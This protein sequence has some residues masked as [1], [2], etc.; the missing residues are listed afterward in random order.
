MQARMDRLP[1]FLRRVGGKRWWA[2]RDERSQGSGAPA[3]FSRRIVRNSYGIALAVWLCLGLLA[4]FWNHQLHQKS[5]EERARAEAESFLRWELAFRKFVA[6]VG[7][8]YV[9]VDKVPG[10]PYL[11]HVPKRDITTCEGQVLT[12]MNTASIDKAVFRLSGDGMKISIHL[13]S[14]VPLDPSNRLKSWEYPVYA[15]FDAGGGDYYQ[16]VIDHGEEHLVVSHALKPV[17]ACFNCHT[18]KEA[19]NA[20]YLGAISVM[21]PLNDIIA[22]EHSSALQMSFVLS[23]LFLAGL[24]TIGYGYFSTKGRL[25]EK[26]ALLAKEREAQALFQTLTEFSADWIFWLNP[27]CSFRYASPAC[28]NISGY[29]PDEFYRDPDLRSRIVH[30]EDA[31]EYARCERKIRSLHQIASSVTPSIKPMEFRIVRRDGAVRMVR[32]TAQVLMDDEGN[33]EGIRGVISDLTEAKEQ[34]ALFHNQ[35]RLAAMGEMIS[36][37][38]H[39]WRQPINAL[40]LILQNVAADYRDGVLDEASIQ[41]YVKTGLN[42]TEKMS[43]TID[44]FRNFARPVKDQVVFDVCQAIHQ[45]VEMVED[46]YLAGGIFLRATCQHDGRA[47]VKGFPN[48]LVQ[49]LLNLFANARDAIRENK[50]NHGS[51]ATTVAIEDGRLVMTVSDNGGGIPVDV[52]DKIFSPYF[53]TKQQGTGIGLYMCLRIVER[54]GGVIRVN[55]IPGGTAMV[56]DLPLATAE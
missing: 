9:S 30:E 6:M 26:M 25:R 28:L 45:A 53:T 37:I 13:S 3:D 20:P 18:N 15:S 39:Q 50:V 38:A 5:V 4:A 21:V 36:N 48:E 54:M 22:S 43:S 55:A 33:V 1:N 11:S 16:R 32:Q 10:N 2:R 31:A 34:E 24:V 35:S 47:L 46:S 51:I 49:V 52:W 27:D 12:L 23:G 56:I 8:V 40:G 41:H 44:D 7:G 29:R 14:R 17:P 42:L 19:L